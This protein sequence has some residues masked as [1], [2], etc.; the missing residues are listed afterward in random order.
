MASTRRPL[1]RGLIT[2]A[3]LE[4]LQPG[5]VL[6]FHIPIKKKWDWFDVRYISHNNCELIVADNLD[7][8]KG[9]RWS[10][11]VCGIQPMTGGRY[12]ESYICIR[13]EELGL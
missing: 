6:R 11:K 10:Q 12:A 13:D 8:I 3:R 7:D 1:V 4:E 9:I 5:V 2:K